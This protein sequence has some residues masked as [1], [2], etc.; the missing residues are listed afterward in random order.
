MMRR[1]VLLVALGAALVGCTVV[2]NQ[3]TGVDNGNHPD[4]RVSSEIFEGIANP[5]DLEFI[6]QMMLLSAQARAIAGEGLSRSGTSE[7]RTQAATVYETQGVAL[8]QLEAWRAE[9]F[10]DAPAAA[11]API[12]ISQLIPADEVRSFDQRFVD[13][14]IAQKEQMLQLATDANGK[15]E[16]VQ[17]DTLVKS[18]LI[19]QPNDIARLKTYQQKLLETT[20]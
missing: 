20:L 1:A 3:G 15:V 10:A 17:L 4:K 12:E 2:P 13:A 5:V 11:M 7:L 14:L 6:D 16:H 18:T 8:R 9:W 19:Y